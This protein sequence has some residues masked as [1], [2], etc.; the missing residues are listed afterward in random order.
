MISVSKYVTRE[1]WIYFLS[2][3]WVFLQLY[4]LVILK[5]DFTLKI[6]HIT[7]ALILAFLIKPLNRFVDSILIVFAIGTGIYYMIKEEYIL[8]RI[9]LLTPVSPVDVFFGSLL[10]ILTVESVRRVAGK[11]LTIFM[12]LFVVYWLIG[13]LIP[14]VMHH[15]VS[16]Q[17]IFEQIA[18]SPDGILGFLLY[19]SATYVFMFILF[20]SILYGTGIGSVYINVALRAVGARRGGAAK[21]AII[22]SSL[23]GTISGASVSNVLATGTFTIPM[24]KK[25]GYK[26]S[27]A[28]AVEA[29]ASTGGQLVPPIMGAAA[30]IMAEVLNVNYLYI[31]TAAVIP[32]FL[33]YASIFITVDLI[34]QRD[35][36]KG[37]EVEISWRNILKNSYLFLPLVVLIYRL[38]TTFSPLGAVIDSLIFTFVLIFFKILV[39]DKK[40]KD[41]KLI[42][43]SFSDAAK[44]A[45][46]VACILA[47]V[48]MVVGIIGLTGLGQKL[49]SV[50][51][52]ISQGNIAVLTVL[53]MILAILLG[54]GMP[55]TAAYVLTASI[56]AP[57][58]IH[59]GFDKIATHLFVFYFAML[60]AVT[61]PVAVA[62]YAAASLAGS[63]IEE[64]GF[65][66]F[67]L[68]IVSYV[69]P[70]LML[71]YREL[72]H[73]SINSLLTVFFTLFGFV[74]LSI[75]VV[76]YF[77]KKLSVGY[78]IL[79]VFLAIL[80]LQQELLFRFLG[81][82][83]L[84]PTLLYISRK[85][86]YKVS[87]NGNS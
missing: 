57:I 49:T 39:I 58:L 47:G 75:A 29:I 4:V 24:M 9:P 59:T 82:V 34:A 87:Q 52:N 63:K 20:S 12:S 23:F 26:P 60:S 73:P 35:G 33:Y 18:L 86:S 5:D 10:I 44:N 21:A 30:F 42:L 65:T 38:V 74:S 1:N 79:F 25:A 22:A 45:T 70:F 8:E 50:I 14:G 27:F 16:L 19:I 83:I 77:R 43:D 64:T 32:A 67:K 71:V 15:G 51:I 81:L 7:F 36:L 53:T 55:T 78:R 17:L 40:P 56:A 66:A 69:I 3:I 46:V 62:S 41:I 61:P 54:M 48:G 72:T 37:F 80:L 31:I 28:A 85:I 6:I 84:M 13:P 11:V 2:S 76:G 68:A